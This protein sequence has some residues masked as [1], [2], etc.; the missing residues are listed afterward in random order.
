MPGP[1]KL[2]IISSPA[3]ILVYGVDALLLET[4]RLV[5]ARAG[6]QVCIATT[7]AEVEGIINIEPID[8]LILCHTL[9]SEECSGA[10]RVSHAMGPK[11]KTLVLQ[12]Q[13][14]TCPAARQ[15]DVFDIFSGPR[16][17]VTTA[18]QILQ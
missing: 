16:A 1:R 5:L 17:L 15:E 12:A 2:T 6:F 8:L 9:S 18:E 7:L 13:A 4:R 3:C 14:P 11:I 10:L